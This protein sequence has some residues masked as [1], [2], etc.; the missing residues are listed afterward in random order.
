MHY[1]ARRRN[2]MVHEGILAMEPED[3]NLIQFACERAL[4]WLLATH[5]KLPTQFHLRE[6]YRCYSL[7]D[8]QLAAIAETVSRLQESRE[9][10][11]KQPR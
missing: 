7:G 9:I 10:V 6:F 8:T 3:L 1:L 2:K 4:G 11:K 5:T